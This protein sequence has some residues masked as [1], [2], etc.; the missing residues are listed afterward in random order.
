MQFAAE[1]EF[2][3]FVSWARYLYWAD[4]QRKNHLDLNSNNDDLEKAEQADE[5]WKTF[6]VSSLWLASTWVVIEG[7]REI[8]AKDDVID[9]LLSGWPHYVDLLRRYRNGVCHYQPKLLDE[10]FE[11][12]KTQGP[13]FGVWAFALNFEFQR[14]LWEWPERLPGTKDQVSELRGILKKMIGWMPS[15]IIPARKRALEELCATALSEIELAG[16]ETSDA[17]KDLLRAIEDVSVMIK[18][19]PDSPHLDALQVQ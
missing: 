8:N 7:W 16:D 3:K 19:M 10:R 17:A 9:R 1:K 2:E 4:L 18:D 6:A 13:N 12:F 11:A 14:F 15:E 5:G